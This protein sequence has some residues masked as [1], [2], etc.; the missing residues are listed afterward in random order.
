M[1]PSSF[2]IMSEMLLRFET[3]K[4]CWYVPLLSK[5]KSR[6]PDDMISVDESTPVVI[7]ELDTK[8]GNVPR[9]ENGSVFPTVSFLTESG[10]NR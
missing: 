10:N 1:V 7:R 3:S 4:D 9:S 5:I 8:G 6:F 2:E